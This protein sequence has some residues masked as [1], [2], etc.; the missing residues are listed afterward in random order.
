MEYN[1]S[2]QQPLKDFKKIYDSFKME[3]LCNIITEF[4]FPMNLVKLIKR[5]LNETYNRARV[6]KNLCD[7]LPI[8]S[9]LKIVVLSPFLFS[10]LLSNTPLRGYM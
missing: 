2:I 3:V 1:E 6:G 8:R 4:G 5:C 7:I 9:G 10:T